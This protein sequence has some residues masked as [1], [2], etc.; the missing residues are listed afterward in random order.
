MATNNSI[1]A[2]IPF[3]VAKGGTGAASMT[4][5]NGVVY[6]NGSN[7]ATISPGTSTHVLTSN[8]S[9]S[10][11]SFQAAGG[12]GIS[13]TL[14]FG[15]AVTVA[16][17]VPPV[18]GDG[19]VYNQGSSLALSNL[20]DNSAG[21][22]YPGNGSG[23]DASFTAPATGVYFF[24]YFTSAFAGD[25]AADG[26]F[27]TYFYI[28]ISINGTALPYVTMPAKRN[29]PYFVGDN[30]TIGLWTT[31]MPSLNS[32]DIVKFQLVGGGGGPWSGPYSVNIY[33]C[34]IA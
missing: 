27:P 6:Y 2:P 28:A 22:W 12:G 30:Y 7:L 11:P 29:I 8:G 32:G 26:N 34:R 5:T 18:T 10:A 15:A 33:G 3:A 24:S 13:G 23:T 9:G 16:V 1:N 17:L 4:N 25:H 21:A 19:T 20:Y 31:Q 14:S